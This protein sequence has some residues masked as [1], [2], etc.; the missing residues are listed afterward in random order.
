MKSAL[1]L[2]FGDYLWRRSGLAKHPFWVSY[3]YLL[4]AWQSVVYL[5]GFFNLLFLAKETFDLQ[6]TTVS[7]LIFILIFLFILPAKNFIVVATS[8]VIYFFTLLGYVYHLMENS[9]LHGQLLGLFF[10]V[11]VLRPL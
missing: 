7:A 8:T 4:G 5:F 11:L 2:S 3:I 9:S 10:I 1:S 6:A